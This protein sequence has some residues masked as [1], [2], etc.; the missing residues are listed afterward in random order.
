MRYLFSMFL[1]VVIARWGYAEL[2]LMV[3]EA[4]PAIDSALEVVKIPTHNEWA[5]LEIV[6]ILKDKELI[7]A[8]LEYLSGDS[9]ISLSS[10]DRENLEGLLEKL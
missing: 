1:W 9:K 6:K 10:A 8:K 7:Q 5:D 2:S 3:P 4:I